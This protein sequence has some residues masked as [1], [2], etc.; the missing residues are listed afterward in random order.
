MTNRIPA[1]ERTSVPRDQVRREDALIRSFG[2]F[3]PQV[4]HFE[5]TARARV[6]FRLDH[7]ILS[8]HSDVNV[9]SAF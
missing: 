5:N 8:A 9:F 7:N 1:N 3:L 2:T 4:R 6:G